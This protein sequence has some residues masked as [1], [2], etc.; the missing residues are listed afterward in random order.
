[1]GL[2]ELINNPVSQVFRRAYIKR[3]SA[4]TGL[5]ESTWQEIT[6]YIIRWGNI[7]ISL[8]DVRL[9]R[10]NMAG[11]NLIVDNKDGKFNDENN[12]N[13]L[14]YG[15]LTRY[16]SLLKIEAGYQT[17]PNAE[18]WGF[19]WGFAW[20]ATT[21]FPTDPTQGIFIL[22]QEIPI[23]SDNRVQ[24]AASSLKSIFDGVKAN[25]IGGLG[26]TQTAS[27][28]ITKIR[29]HTDG[30]GSY[31]FRQYISAAS[32]LIQTTTNY[33]N[34]A[35]TTALDNEGTVWDFMVKTAEA[36]GFVVYINRFGQL[37]F[38]DRTPNTSVSQFSFYG[39]G[40]PRQNIIS[41]QSYREA[42]NKVYNSIRLKYLAADTNT[43]YVT[44]G[45]T[46]VI[47]PANVQWKYGARIYEL[48]N[49]WIAN[50]ATAQTIADGLF[51]EF[52]S[53]KGEVDLTAK[54]HPELDPLDRVD[55]SHYSYSLAN[56][57]LWSA[58]NWGDAK[59]SKEGENFD[60]ESKEFKVLSKNINLDDFSETFKL[61]E[62]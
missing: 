26:P 45:T 32:W 30:S 23:S 36:E 7:N 44:V 22:D 35:T 41:V 28:L 5:L 62:V 53:V 6:P 16:G 15:Y 18:G 12:F 27:E 4:T 57:T 34:I 38:G 50:T 39:Q 54:F 13:S 31:V 29:D 55:V 17:L 47:T 46:T 40:F 59:W 58:F 60:W 48:E 20:G 56:K 1:M 19:P 37:V 11:A 33:Y 25:E 8:D 2:P 3:R 51:T 49:T 24:V 43:S 9:N 21:E 61:R 10:F 42:L 14:W 52:S